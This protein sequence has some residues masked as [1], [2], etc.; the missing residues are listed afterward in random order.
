MAK[1]GGTYQKDGQ[2]KNSYMECGVVMENEQGERSYK[3]KGLPVN[4]DGWLNEWDL[5][6]AHT[7]NQAGLNQQQPAPPQAPPMQ[8]DFDDSMPF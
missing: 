1:D 2:T 8:N 3:I 6:G 4:F 5:R 7:A